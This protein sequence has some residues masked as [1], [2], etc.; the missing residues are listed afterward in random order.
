MILQKLADF[1]RDISLLQQILV[2]VETIIWLLEEWLSMTLILKL[3]THNYSW[4]SPKIKFVM[5]VPFSSKGINR[6]V[7]PE[8]V[9]Q[10]PV[11]AFQLLKINGPTSR[12]RGNLFCFC[13]V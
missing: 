4:K 1:T 5:F 9:F 11:C 12:L 6:K 7:I 3:E 10:Q 8:N 13:S 2:I